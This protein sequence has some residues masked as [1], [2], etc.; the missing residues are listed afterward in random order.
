MDEGR[1]HQPSLTERAKY[2]FDKSMSAGTVALIGWLAAL[3]L[4]IIVAASLFIVIV[5]IAP[6]GEQRPHDFIE[7]GWESLM[8]TLDSGT[9]G[10]DNGWPYRIVM[11]KPIASIALISS[12]GLL[13]ARKPEVALKLF[14]R[15]VGSFGPKA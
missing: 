15:L 4:A 10:G 11:E 12:V 2:L 5:G 14:D 7:T 6:E 8:R 3:S 9:V 13:I 1:H